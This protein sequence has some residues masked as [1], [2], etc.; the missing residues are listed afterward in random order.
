MNPKKPT[1]ISQAAS[2]MG[3]KGGKRTLEL[4]GAEHFSA[5][6]KARKTFGGGYP[7]G[8]PRKPKGK[9]DGGK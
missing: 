8:R 5:A 9:K 1:A 6:S 2:M 4:H 7:K 3:K